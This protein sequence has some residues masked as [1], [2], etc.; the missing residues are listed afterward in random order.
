MDLMDFQEHWE[1]LVDRAFEKGGYSR[2]SDDER[3]WFNL[4]SLTQ[5]IYDGGIISYYYNSSADHLDDLS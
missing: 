2:L 5:A 3:V 1:Q 4:Q